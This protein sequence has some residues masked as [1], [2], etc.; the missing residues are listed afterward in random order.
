[1]Y[2]LTELKKWYGVGPRGGAGLGLENGF[3][4][5]ITSNIHIIIIVCLKFEH[6]MIN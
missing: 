3:T 4:L 5:I 6:L 2:G 1:M